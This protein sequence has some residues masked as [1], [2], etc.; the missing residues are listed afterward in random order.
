MSAYS[1]ADWD[2]LRVLLEEG[3]PV[4]CLEYSPGFSS[5]HLALGAAGWAVLRMAKNMFCVLDQEPN[6]SVVLLAGSCLKHLLSLIPEK[7]F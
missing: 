1:S 3:F 7:P 2:I 4:A 5:H 6:G